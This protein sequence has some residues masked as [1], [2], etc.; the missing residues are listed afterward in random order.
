MYFD[1]SRSLDYMSELS[2]NEKKTILYHTIIAILCVIS[3]F[4]W[5][6]PSRR[7]QPPASILNQ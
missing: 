3:I 2:E 1:I 5:T 4:I 6:G 7:M